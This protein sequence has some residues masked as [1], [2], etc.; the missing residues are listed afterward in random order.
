VCTRDAVEPTRI[1][2][3]T[4]LGLSL[5]EEDAGKDLP[6]VLAEV[7]E[8]LARQEEE[9]RRRRARLAEL[10]RRA[11]NGDGLPPEGPVSPELDAIFEAMARTAEK[12][13]GAE[14]AMAAKEREPPALLDGAAPKETKNR[15]PRWCRH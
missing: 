4:E 12:L 10:L 5:D 13:P 11:E 2:R 6:E 9:I 15:R 1:R 14:P 7:D 3:L 8:D